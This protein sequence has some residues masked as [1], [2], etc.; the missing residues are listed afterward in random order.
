MNLVNENLTNTI[1]PFNLNNIF[2]KLVQ[3]FK[4][5]L[6]EGELI[7]RE[8]PYEWDTKSITEINF[9]DNMD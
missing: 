2:K 6:F 4:N 9:N 7:G 8:Y 5:R 1:D 3:G